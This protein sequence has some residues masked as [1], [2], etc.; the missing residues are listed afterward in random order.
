MTSKAAHQRRHSG[1]KSFRI[2]AAFLL[3]AVAAAAGLKIASDR[4]PADT[5]RS[6]AFKWETLTASLAASDGARQEAQRDARATPEGKSYFIPAFSTGC[7][8]HPARTRKTG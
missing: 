3:A 2:S 8:G 7:T 1:S 4:S 5:G 6:R